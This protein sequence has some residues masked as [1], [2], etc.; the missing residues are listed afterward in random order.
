LHDRGGDGERVEEIDIEAALVAPH[1]PC[2]L[3]GVAFH[4]I[5]GMF[6]ATTNGLA[7]NAIRSDS[8][9]RPSGDCQENKPGTS[10]L[11]GGAADCGAGFDGAA[12]GDLP[13]SCLTPAEAATNVA[14]CREEA[15]LR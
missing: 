11:V 4:S 5:S 2:P 6:T 13:A 12:C 10:P 3:D 8:V 9:G 14:S 1:T 15:P 7:L